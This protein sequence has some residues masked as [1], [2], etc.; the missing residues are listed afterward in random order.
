MF[1]DTPNTLLMFTAGAFVLGWLI[2]RVGAALKARSLAKKRDPR[3]DRIRSLEAE[4]RIATSEAEKAK[5][6]LAAL[7]KALQEAKVDIER[8]DNVITEQ[9]AKVAR[10][11]EDLKD[12]VIKTRELREELTD[13]AAESV[14]SQ[15]KLREVETELSVA[16]ASTDLIATGVLDYT[17]A[18]EAL[19]EDEIAE[20][21]VKSSR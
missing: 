8:R 9:Q 1:M 11:R 7:E 17:V 15:V 3:D 16:Q 12:S 10:L 21:R 4:L 20:E 5:E 2:G 19:D 18:P 13:R 6:S 14:R